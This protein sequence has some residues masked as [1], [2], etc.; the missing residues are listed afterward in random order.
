MET[1]TLTAPDISCEHCKSTIERE[2][3]TAEGIHSVA[4]DVPTKQVTVVYDAGRTSRET[5]IAALNEEG[6]PVQR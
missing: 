1:L 3:G 2:I 6:Y 4:V 5:I